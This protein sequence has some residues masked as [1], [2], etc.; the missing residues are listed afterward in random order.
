MEFQMHEEYADILS[1]TLPGN[2][3]VTFPS[4]HYE[5]VDIKSVL[6]SFPF[7]VTSAHCLGAPAC[8]PKAIVQII[9]SREVV[10]RVTTRSLVLLQWFEKALCGVPRGYENRA[11]RSIMTSFV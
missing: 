7:G 4:I 5:D 2:G 8:L 10:Q 3:Y 11:L 6:D 9:C 1:R